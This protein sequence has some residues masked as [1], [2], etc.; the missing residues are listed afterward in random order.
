M[1]SVCREE[2]QDFNSCAFTWLFFWDK[3]TEDWKLKSRPAAA[4]MHDDLSSVSSVFSN[5]LLGRFLMKTISG[6][7][8]R[9]V[10]IIS[11]EVKFKCAFD[12]WFEL[13]QR[14]THA[15]NKKINKNTRNRNTLQITNKKMKMWSLFFGKLDL[16][17]F[18]N[19][20]I[21]ARISM[22]D[23]AHDRLLLNV[24]LTFVGLS[25]I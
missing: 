14:S 16:H 3:S 2:R 17:K 18:K 21:P 5:F 12:F 8:S 20:Y 13:V 11:H 19:K 25:M 4:Q 24:S 22:F 7:R 23:V 10:N 9:L 15:S 6:K 1:S